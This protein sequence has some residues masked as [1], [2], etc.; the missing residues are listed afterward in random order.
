MCRIER[1]LSSST[2]FINPGLSDTAYDSGFIKR[3]AITIIWLLGSLVRKIQ[4]AIIGRS[5]KQVST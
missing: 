4:C 5:I 1:L 2:A 3:N